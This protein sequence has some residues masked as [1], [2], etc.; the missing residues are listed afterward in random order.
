MATV[1]WVGELWPGEVTKTLKILMD[2]VL[3]DLIT[4]RSFMKQ[5]DTYVDMGAQYWTP[6][7]DRTD[8]LRQSLTQSGHLVSFDEREISEDPH[9]GTVK[10]HLIC[11]DRKGFRS[12][13]EY[14]L[15]G[16]CFENCGDDAFF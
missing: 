6:Q 3:T 14:L 12:I 13:V 2:I 11:P 5:R 10:T 4:F 16:R 7:S 8:E 1:F 9:R 15:G